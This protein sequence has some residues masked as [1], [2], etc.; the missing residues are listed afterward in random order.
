MNFCRD[1][2]MTSLLE[3]NQ[4]VLGLFHGFPEWGEVVASEPL[5]TRRL[6]DIPET[7][8]VDMIKIDIQG[9]ELMAFSHAT[10]RLKTTLVIQTEVEFLPM[11]VGQPLFAEVELFLR[12]QGFM[13][14]RFHPTVSR[15]MRPLT[16]ADQLNAGFGQLVWGDAIFVRDFTRLAALTDGQ[17]VKAAAILNDCYGSIDLVVHLLA[18]HDKRTGGTLAARYLAA[19]NAAAAAPAIDPQADV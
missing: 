18:E 4:A 15:L 12:S 14:H 10:L 16:T 11:Y 19:L 7:A 13:L 17:L 5:H 6:D 3:P 9:G 2:G 8:G 1:P